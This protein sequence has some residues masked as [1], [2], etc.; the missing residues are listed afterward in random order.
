M[1]FCLNKAAPAALL[2]I[3]RRDRM[4][5]MFV[6][7]EKLSVVITSVSV[8]TCAFLRLTYKNQIYLTYGKTR[9]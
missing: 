1:I 9:R 3:D 2:F 7:S 5:F 6:T 4:K 8:L